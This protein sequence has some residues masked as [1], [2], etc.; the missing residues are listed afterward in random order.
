MLIDWLESLLESMTSVELGFVLEITVEGI[1]VEVKV[2][3]SMGAGVGEGAG[4]GATSGADLDAAV[5]TRM[6]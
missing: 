3:G 4:A 2:R 5:M 6:F 1:G